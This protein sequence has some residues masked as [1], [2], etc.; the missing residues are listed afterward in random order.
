MEYCDKVNYYLKQFTDS[1]IIKDIKPLYTKSVS[2][3]SIVFNLEINGIETSLG[4][5][6]VS[7]DFYLSDG[8]KNAISFASFLAR[9][10]MMGR[11]ILPIR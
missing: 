1:I 5:R 7:F 3:Q 8:D 10:D 9:L 11:I 6:D 4:N 2:L